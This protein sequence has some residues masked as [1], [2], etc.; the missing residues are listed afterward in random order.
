MHLFI[1][2]CILLHAV[3]YTLSM[4]RSPVGSKLIST[5]LHPLSQRRSIHVHVLGPFYSNK[6]PYQSLLVS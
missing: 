1:Y 4:P 5:A 6:A 2:G 3:V